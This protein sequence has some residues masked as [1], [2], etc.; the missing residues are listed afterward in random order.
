LPVGLECRKYPVV[1]LQLIYKVKVGVIIRNGTKA[2]IYG[3][4]KRVESNFKQIG[5]NAGF[6]I[7]QLI[8]DILQC[9][10]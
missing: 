3:S 4:I 10:I 6:Y 1:V 8:V 5:L 7:D 2:G 9:F